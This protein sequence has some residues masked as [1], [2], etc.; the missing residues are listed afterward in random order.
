MASLEFINYVPRRPEVQGGRLLWA[1]ATLRP[2]S[3]LPQICWDNGTTWSEANLWALETA[4]SQRKDIKTVKS[5]MSHLLAYAKWLEAEE[6]K[7]WHFPARDSD[8]CLT[9][10]RGALVQARDAGMTAPS[11][12]SQRMAVAIRFYRW[13]LNRGL[14]S[15]DWPIWSERQIGIRLID[16]FGLAH[17]M[18]VT[19]TDLAIPNRKVAGAF[20]LEDGLLP[21]S[22]A[23]MRA[24]LDVADSNSSEE[25]GLM[26]R[27]GFQSG[28]RLN[29][30]TDLK[31]QTLLNAT[32]DPILGC[33][34]LAVGPAAKPPVATK[35]GNSGF[36]PIPTELLGALLRYSTST[37]RLKRQAKASV[38]DRAHLFLTRYGAR[39]NRDTCRAVNVEM[40]RLREAGRA[41]GV[42][43]LREFHF[44]RTRPT[45]A[46][47][48]LRLAL[49]YLTVGDA[50]SLVREACLHKDEATTLRYVR[51]LEA[52][53]AMAEAANAFTEAFLGLSG[54]VVENDE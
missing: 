21:V 24:I 9:R 20:Q 19:S 29:S 12:A 8:R 25:L 45:F 22:L 3:R 42:K 10:F 47:E 39:Y 31:V 26:L 6:I 36:V 17:T 5:A 35:F 30:I 14:L 1:N 23:D 33:H 2:I 27:T 49:R 11:T 41:A 37:R 50:V 7:W 46:T 54:T 38:D 13:T 51:F 48:L 4:T 44:H 18:R 40:L 16:G 53:K 52:N 34:R 32:V 28:L 15:T 43:I